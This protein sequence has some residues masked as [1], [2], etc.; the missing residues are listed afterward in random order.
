MEALGNLAMLVVLAFVRYVPAVVLPAMSPLAWAPA[1]V[2]IVLALALAWLTVLSMPKLP[3]VW[4]GGNVVGWMAAI[5]HELI[6][7]MVFGMVVMLPKAALH[8]SGWLLDM[9]AGLGAAALFQPGG[10]SD[11]QSLLGTALTLLGTV[12][13]FVLDLHVELYRAL[14]ASTHVLPVGGNGAG[15]QLQGFMALLGKSFLLAVL[16]VAPVMLGLFVVDVGVAYT[17]RSM[18]QAN[19]YFLALPLKVAVAMLLFAATM[20]FIPALLGRLFGDALG[21]IPEILGG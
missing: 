20:P 13:F 3:M 15:W 12:I 2:R 10:Q 21:R 5:V 14:V 9:Q 8:M 16:V 7:G 4:Q 11:M 6:I 17:S 18:P 19:V 1:L